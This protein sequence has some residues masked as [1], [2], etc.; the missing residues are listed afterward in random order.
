MNLNKFQNHH[1]VIFVVLT[2][3]VVFSL[4]KTVCAQ[5]PFKFSEDSSFDIHTVQNLLSTDTISSLVKDGENAYKKGDYETAL[6]IFKEIT[7]IN[8][9]YYDAW[10]GIGNCLFN[11][12]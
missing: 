5:T 6:T 1:V 12:G 3:I 10:I 11:L 7:D 2:F 4:N 9:N 8:P